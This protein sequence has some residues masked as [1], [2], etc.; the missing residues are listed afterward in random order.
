MPTVSDVVPAAER[1][2]AENGASTSGVKSHPFVNKSLLDDE[3]LQ[4]QSAE[5]W[6]AKP[7]HLSRRQLWERMQL[8]ATEEM[9]RPPHN[10]GN[11]CPCR[12][13]RSHV[14]PWSILN[15]Q[16]FPGPGDGLE[17]AGAILLRPVQIF[18]SSLIPMAAKYGPNVLFCTPNRTEC[19]LLALCAAKASTRASSF[20]G[21][22]RL[23]LPFDHAFLG[24]VGEALVLRF[25]SDTS[26]RWRASCSPTSSCTTRWT[27]AWPSCWATSSAR[28]RCSACSWCVSSSRPTRRTRCGGETD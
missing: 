13:P 12:K 10:A 18:P 24:A 6:R 22:G 28:R 2:S 25:C 17:H 16:T 11:C 26:P 27:R 14:V 19:T 7:H 5:A 1:R 20:L 21:C 4:R 3:I 23:N 9:V 15:G 8:E